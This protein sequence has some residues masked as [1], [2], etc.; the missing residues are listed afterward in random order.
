MNKTVH[1]YVEKTGKIEKI[2][3]ISFARYN[4]LF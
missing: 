3:M 1:R 4:Y 2:L